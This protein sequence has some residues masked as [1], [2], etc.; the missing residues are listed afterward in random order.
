MELVE[1]TRRRWVRI[2][3]PPALFAL[4]FAVRALPF[5]TVLIEGRPLFFGADVYYHMRRIV[6]S[7]VRFPAALGFD[8]YLNFPDGGRA[9]WTPFFDWAIAAL[10]HPFWGPLTP[11]QLER[12]AI[13]IP[14]L[15]GAATVV[16]LYFLAQKHF[17]TAVAFVAGAVLSVLSAHFWYSQVGFIDHHAA[18]ALA[19]TLVLAA[20][21]GLLAR[22]SREPLGLRPGSRSAVATGGSMALAL[23]LWPG[24]LLHV[25][26]VETGLLVFLLR[27]SRRE[28]AIG[29]ARR[30]ALLH[31]VAFVLVFPFGAGSTWSQWSRFSPVVLSAFQP[32]YF[33]AAALFSAACAACWR[34]PRAGR[35]RA[36]RGAS[37]L[38]IGAAL[39]AVSA[40]LLPGL[41]YAAGDAWEWFAKRDSFQAHVAESSP[42]F[43]AG[44]QFTLV[45]AFM[46]LSIF[47]LAVPVALCVAYGAV[48]RHRHRA[49]VLLFLWWTLGLSIVTVF[50]KRFFNSASVA[51]SLLLA[52]SVCWAYT[53][54]P[55]SVIR[56]AWTRRL[57]KGVL[58]LA[59]I[60]LLLPVL[61]TY[62]PYIANQIGGLQDRPV[63]VSAVT[64]RQLAVVQ[65]ANWL[66]T[67]TPET[68][69]WL[70]PTVRPEYGILAP[71]TIGHVLEY[72]ARRPTVT[73][74]FGDDIGRKNYLL[75][76]R[77]YQSEEDAAADLLDRLGVRYVVSQY[78]PDYLGE[79][80]VPGSMFFTL[81]RHDGSAFEPA[82][83]E[84][85]R[86]PTRAL[87]RHRMI[88][89][90]PPLANTTPPR[91]SLY[92]IFEYVA[93]AR[94]VG[95]AAPGERIRATL[96]VRTNRRRKFSYTAEAVAAGDGH[97]EFRLPYANSGG[98]PGVR[99]G[100]HY[101]LEC[102]GE[103]APVSVDE[104]AVTTGAR[105]EGPELCPAP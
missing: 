56:R 94:V 101:T 44:D 86:P 60:F 85:Q 47:S 87:V 19:T 18:V 95:R 77:Y 28:D 83:N 33:A 74:N 49:P 29:F 104:R 10:L 39:L 4:A 53:K 68:S 98:P 14:P 84:H 9:I 103:T 25:G 50:Q 71:W 88:Y 75:A 41:P 15:L 24:S 55:S 59:T 21:M 90:S 37:A 69:G 30:L 54:L 76:R 42:L 13:W 64:R 27:C 99:V 80:P 66:R 105:I 5:Q 65:M 17:G 89:E 62:W 48:R 7:I 73:D 22:A 102:R 23:L 96:P 1:G 40:W 70:D 36:S 43:F 20:A 58:V 79:D 81:F 8:P 63:A 34:H 82:S 92:K 93:G 35:T 51:I 91:D 45:M 100:P 38:A 67:H 72:E 61:G 12:I 52:L 57:A 16:A 26:L 78:A 2:A 46:R 3:A 11:M 32:W 6:Y 31:G 97:Y